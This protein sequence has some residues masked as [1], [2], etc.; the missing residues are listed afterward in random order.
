LTYAQLR[1]SIQTY[2]YHSNTSSTRLIMMCDLPRALSAPGPVEPG[3][4]GFFA[5]GDITH[6]LDPERMEKSIRK[7]PSHA[8]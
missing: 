4:T 7:S 2:Q 5:P 3:G 1:I 8:H 6:T